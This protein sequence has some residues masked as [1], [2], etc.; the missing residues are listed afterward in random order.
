MI[1]K[2]YNFLNHSQILTK[3]NSFF[4]LFKIS[5]S[6]LSHE[7]EVLLKN[8]LSKVF[9]ID[10]GYPLIRLG[11]PHDGGYL[12]PDIL[13]QI[14]YCISPGVGKDKKMQSFEDDLLKKNIISYLADGTVDYNGVHNFTKKNIKDFNDDKN[15]TLETF[16]NNSVKNSNKLILQMDIE[17]D[18]ISVIYNSSIDLLKRFKCM[19]IEFHQLDFL[20][21]H[22]E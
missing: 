17:G 4:S 8:F 9:I 3:I 1:K 6:Y 14:D 16:V 11:N 20:L 21:K 18:E 22:K 2:F 5:I 7:K 19:V 10:S 15:I 12:I 13:D